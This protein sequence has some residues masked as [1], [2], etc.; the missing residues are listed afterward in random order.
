MATGFNWDAPWA[1]QS[2]A[3][4]TPDSGKWKLYPKSSGWFTVDDGG[5]EHRLTEHVIATSQSS[6]YA[7]NW[8]ASSIVE[9]TLTGSVT[10]TFSN[11]AAARAMTLVVVQGGSGSYTLT[12]PAAVKWAGG[13][14][15]TLSTG[16]GDVDVLTF[17]VRA[18]GSTVLGFPAGLDMA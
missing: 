17:F 8:L 7:V 11:L 2:A 14:A 15:P 5:V 6:S 18:D 10:L 13:A 12:Y 3:P 16:V 1:E 9:I 4:T